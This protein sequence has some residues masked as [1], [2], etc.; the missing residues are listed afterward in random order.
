VAPDVESTLRCIEAPTLLLQ[1]DP[2]LGGIL[3]DLEAEA[4]A[5]QIHDCVHVKLPGIG[6]NIHA[7]ATEQFLR[8]VIP[9]LGSLE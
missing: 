9:F 6:H 2:A 8:L 1:A 4:A 5:S 7:A 3:P